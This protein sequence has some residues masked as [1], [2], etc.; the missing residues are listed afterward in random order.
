MALPLRRYMNKAI[1]I[2]RGEGEY[3]V[4][5]AAIVRLYMESLGRKEIIKRIWK[6][7]GEPLVAPSMYGR[8]GRACQLWHTRKKVTEE[9]SENV[10]GN[11]EALGN[12]TPSPEQNNRQSI[13]PQEKA[14]LWGKML[15]IL[16]YLSERS[17]ARRRKRKE[18]KAGNGMWYMWNDDLPE[19]RGM[20]RM[21]YV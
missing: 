16:L 6:W 3:V 17:Q 11:D 7:W 15:L 13:M 18:R 14:K 1:D 20:K 8:E 21:L 10:A 19:N 12:A 5:V 9:M 2:V 4:G